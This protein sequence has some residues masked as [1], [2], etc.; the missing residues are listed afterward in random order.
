MKTRH[1]SMLWTLGL[2]VVSFVPCLKMDDDLVDCWQSAILFIWY[3]GCGFAIVEDSF[4]FVRGRHYLTG[5][6]ELRCN[7]EESIQT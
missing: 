5:I 7:E 3:V 4:G 6:F 2:K 1:T